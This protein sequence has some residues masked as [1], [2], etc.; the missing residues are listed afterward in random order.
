M[1]SSGA[2][3]WNEIIHPRSMVSFLSQ[4]FGLDRSSVI[5]S[6]STVPR[7]L[8]VRNGVKP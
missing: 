1:F 3:D 6:I 2:R 8:L 7:E 5:I 4:V